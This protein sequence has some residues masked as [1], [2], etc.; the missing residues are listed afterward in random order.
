MSSGTTNPEI[1]PQWLA[2]AEEALIFSDRLVS[3]KFNDIDSS[4]SEDE[5]DALQSSSKS[6]KSPEVDDAVRRLYKAST[7][8]LG[9][10]VQV[11]L[12]HF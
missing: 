9:F 1:E 5:T 7:K 6:S 2:L 10:A 3:E 4:P 12:L 11:F 8:K